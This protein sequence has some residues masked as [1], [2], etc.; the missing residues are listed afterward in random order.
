MVLFHTERKTNSSEPCLFETDPKIHRPD[1]D[2]EADV[3]S[4]ESE[5]ERPVYNKA[6]PT[7][8]NL[9][10]GGHLKFVLAI[11]NIAYGLFFERK[12]I[13]KTVES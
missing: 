12:S 3:S 7:S 10:L 6:N 13:S 5:Q 2:E 9:D 11:C 1:P 4:E 8:S